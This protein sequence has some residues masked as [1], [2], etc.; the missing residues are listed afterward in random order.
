MSLSN[1]FQR[2]LGRS[3]RKPEFRIPSVPEDPEQHPERLAVLPY[4]SAGKGIDVGCGH[5]KSSPQCIGVDLIAGGEKGEHGVVMNQVSVADVQAS[6]DDLHMFAD[7][8]LD[9]V[10][11]RHNLEH[12]VD[13]LK[14]LH[15][16]KRVLK[17]GGKLAVVLPD[18]RH[19]D[20]IALDPTHK[21]VFTPDSFRRYMEG[22]GGFR[23]L[24]VRDAVEHWSFL[25]A[26]EKL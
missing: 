17:P 4:C 21:H 23:E 2:A 22:V 8:E 9:F 5:R 11:A 12:Y 16:W 7:G 20:T 15:E 25:A 26:F 18:D 6:G 13:V 3:E 24:E 14:T 1:L 10:V 19:V